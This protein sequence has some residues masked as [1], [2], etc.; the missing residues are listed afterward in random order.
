MMKARAFLMKPNLSLFIAGLGR[1]D[2]MEGLER[3]RVIVFSSLQ[4][5][6]TLIETQ[7][8]DEFYSEFLG[9]E[10]LAVPMH[11]SDERIKSW[12]NLEA[13]DEFT[14]RGIEK[15]IT[16]CDV[17]LSSAGWVGINLPNGKEATF[18]AWTP[19]KRGIYVR[20][21]SL[22]PYGIQLKGTRIQGSLAY[23]VGDSFTYK[24]VQKMNR[25]NKYP[26]FQL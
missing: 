4:L 10:V 11:E 20:Q 23:H 7:H 26:T 1:L 2:Y 8:A 13:G 12:P 15:H 25:E 17:V 3:I 5:P 19:Q 22:L 24:R 21:P 6:V 14:V 16:V 18:K 9:S